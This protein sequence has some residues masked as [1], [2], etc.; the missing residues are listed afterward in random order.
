MSEKYK[1]LFE[2]I[3]IGTMKLRNRTV[4]APM[5]TKMASS[6]GEVTDRLIAYHAARAKGGIALI[7]LENT[8]IDWEL[9]R[10]PGNPARIDDDRFICG[11]ADLVQAVHAHGA[12][13][14]TQLHQPG[15]QQAVSNTE[16]GRLPIAPSATQSFGGDMPRVMTEEDIEHYIQLYVAGAV[17]SQMAG[18]DGVEFH[19][20]HGYLPT[21][22]L[23]PRTNLRTDKWGGSFE[24]RARFIVEIIRRSRAALGPDYPLLYRY[25]ADE[26]IDGGYDLEEGIKFG[27]L[28]ENEGIDCLD[29]SAGIYDSMP[30]IFPTQGMPAGCL[31]PLAA[32]VKAEVNIPVIAV[33]GLGW[34]QDLACEILKK[35]EADMISMGRS[36]LADPDLPNKVKEDRPHEIRKCIRCNDCVGFVFRGWRTGCILNPECGHEYKDLVKPAAAPKRIVVVGAGVAGLEY[37]VTATR[38]GHSVTVLEKSDQI[39]GLINLAAKPAYK[40]DE[41][42]ALIAYYDAMV[43]KLGIDAQLNTPATL[44]TV[45]EYDPEVVVVAIGMDPMEPP[46]PGAD[47]LNAVTDVLSSDGENLGKKVCVVGGGGVGCDTALCLAAQGKDVTILEMREA[48]ALDENYLLLLQINDEVAKAGIKVLTNHECVSISANGVKAKNKKGEIDLLFDDVVV[49]AGFKPIDPSGLADQFQEN[50]YLVQS[51]GTCVD[52]GRI[53]NAVWGGFRAALQA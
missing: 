44:E 14:V 45:A 35:G 19:G 20:A 29:V 27:K 16:G 53:Y 32:A 17:R 38:R 9:G 8:C 11:L 50:G 24:N 23:S 43:K 39:G 34:D 6:N 51:I 5:H 47:K 7:V 4:M 3:S 48:L 25:S 22:F 46:I 18:F 10:A 2:P 12:K 36:L 15:R 42:L 26:K 41:L 49:A 40:K 37:A 52:P 13:M 33:G 31:A 30:W 28:L 1:E 21:Q